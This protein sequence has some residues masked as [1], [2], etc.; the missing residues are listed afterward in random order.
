M[1]VLQADNISYQFDNGDR[2]F[3]SLSFTI[4]SQRIGLVGRNGA[5]KS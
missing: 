4:K 1:P 5:G 3:A 2:L